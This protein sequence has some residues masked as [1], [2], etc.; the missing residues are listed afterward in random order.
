MKK[1]YIAPNTIVV[2][3]SMRNHL[4]NVS[5]GENEETI[6]SMDYDSEIGGTSQLTRKSVW[7]DEW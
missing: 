5:Y 7:D 3:L 2:K 6:K 4:M 1:I